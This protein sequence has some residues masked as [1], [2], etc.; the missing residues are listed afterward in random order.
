[1][2]Q[3]AVSQAIAHTT[4][5][6]S[7][8]DVDLVVVPWFE[9][10]ASPAVAGLDRALGGELA[11]ALTTKEFAARPYD[12]FGAGVTDGTWKPRRVLF[13]GA[14]RIGAFTTAAARRIA[15][16]GALAARNRRVARLGFLLRPGLANP[17][18]DFDFAGFMQSVVEGITLAEFSAAST[19]PATSRPRPGKPP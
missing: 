10:D 11:R 14:G 18:G 19:R 8:V 1:M 16:A 5:P 17:A 7:T 9:D 12:L 3:S 2:P 6:L 13:V 15:T 4:A